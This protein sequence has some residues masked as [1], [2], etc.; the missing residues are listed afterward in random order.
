[1]AVIYLAGHGVGLDQQF[2]FLPR[3][4]RRE[5]DEEA[6]IRKHGLAAP[7]LGTALRGIRAL[8]QILILDTC[9]SEAALPIVARAVSFRGLGPAEQRAMTMLA[10]SE[11][12]HLL[13]A[14]TRPG[15]RQ[16]PVSVSLG[17]DFPLGVR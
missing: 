4:M 11:G 12:V 5:P 1:M 6:P 14:S 9:N 8:K 13:A 3:D 7:E 2:Y 16:Y 15:N 17:Q 10:R